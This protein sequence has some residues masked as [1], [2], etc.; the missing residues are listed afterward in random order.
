MLRKSAQKTVSFAI[1]LS[2]YDTWVFLC[3]FETVHFCIESIIQP[4]E[5]IVRDLAPPHLLYNHYVLDLEGCE[6]A[7]CS[8]EPSVTVSVHQT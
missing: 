7:V 3:A 2:D 5:L 1:T 6:D 4:L 8:L